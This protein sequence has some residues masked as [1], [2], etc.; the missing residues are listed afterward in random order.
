MGYR[1]VVLRD[2]D[3]EGRLHER[4]HAVYHVRGDEKAPLWEDEVGVV[5]AA[6]GRGK[7]VRLV[8]D[9]VRAVVRQLRPSIRGVYKEPEPI[10]HTDWVECARPLFSMLSVAG[11]SLAMAVRGAHLQIGNQCCCDTRGV[12]VRSK[13]D[14]VP[15]GWSGVMGSLIQWG[16]FVPAFF[17]PMTR[18][19]ERPMVGA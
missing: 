12:C 10:D 7:H 8:V 5:V 18:R 17:Q 15:T 14:G 1:A 3:K 19:F 13:A 6:G 11:G 9:G 2:A 4:V 16:V